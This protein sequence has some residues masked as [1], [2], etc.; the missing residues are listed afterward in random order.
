MDKKSAGC[1]LGKFLAREQIY[2]RLPH[3]N[4][5][6]VLHSLGRFHV[7]LAIAS[8]ADAAC[9]S[10]SRV[11]RQADELTLLQHKCDDGGNNE[12]AKCISTSRLDLIGSFRLLTHSSEAE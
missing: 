7:A 3:P 9:Y 4:V 5:Q 11:Q 1:V 6:D 8:I 10:L 2:V 12:S